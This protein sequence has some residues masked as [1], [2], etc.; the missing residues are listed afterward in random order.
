MAERINP[1]D[2]VAERIH[3]VSRPPRRI[4]PAE[5]AAALGAEP[6]GESVPKS[7]DPITMAELGNELIKRLRSTGGRPALVDANH[8]CKVP[9]S[10]A[11][12][13][14]L[15]QIIDAIE[16]QTGTRPSLGQ[17]ASVILRVHLESRKDLAVPE[18]KGK[19]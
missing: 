17:I 16:E 19:R 10:P 18:T 2:K 7:A 11:D 4:E 5:F 8:R 13:A 6:C 12:I 1:I 3:D 14:A 9:L 15:E